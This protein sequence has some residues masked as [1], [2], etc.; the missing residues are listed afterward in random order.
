[1]SD[2]R[3]GYAP[4][5]RARVSVARPPCRPTPRRLPAPHN[6][7]APQDRASPRAGLTSSGPEDAAYLCS[8]AGVHQLTRRPCGARIWAD[9]IVG[10][11]ADRLE[12]E[13]WIVAEAIAGL[14]PA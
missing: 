4:Q 9:A 13:L 8:A 2:V 1:M 7:S 10:R 11:N 14:V 6:G 5:R 12:P 3:R